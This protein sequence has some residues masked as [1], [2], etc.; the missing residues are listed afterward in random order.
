[1]REGGPI[2][3]P[4]V[5]LVSEEVV[6]TVLVLLNEVVEVDASERGQDIAGELRGSLNFFQRVPD[7]G[8][9]SLHLHSEAF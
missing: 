6:I 9:L 4:S 2:G 7:D 5:E 1:M 8:F 3:G